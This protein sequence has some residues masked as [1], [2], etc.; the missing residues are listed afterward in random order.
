MEHSRADR[1]VER[2]S[3]NANKI[4]WNWLKIITCQVNRGSK[5]GFFGF[6]FI[7]QFQIL[8]GG[9]AVPASSRRRRL[10]VVVR[11]VK[12]VDEWAAALASTASTYGRIAILAVMASGLPGCCQRSS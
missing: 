3:S 9:E 4:S 2:V 11:G 8:P 1:V 5:F 6:N 10:S 7:F 12:P